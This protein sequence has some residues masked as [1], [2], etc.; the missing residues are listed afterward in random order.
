MEDGL[1]TIA[2]SAMQ[3]QAAIQAQLLHPQIDLR[4]KDATA[5]FWLEFLSALLLL[6][7]G[8]GYLYS[9]LTTPGL[10]RLF[11]LW[12]LWTIGLMV[13][14]TFGLLGGLCLLPLLFLT[15]FFVAYKSADDLRRSIVAAKAAQSKS[16]VRSLDSLDPLISSLYETREREPWEGR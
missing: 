9:G 6:L 2:A 8:V 12:L 10:I 13:V 5:A 4:S 14:A 16:Q 7:G 1:R 3:R 11:G 15:H